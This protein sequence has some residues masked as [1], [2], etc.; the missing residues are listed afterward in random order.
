M[1]GQAW[2]AVALLL[3]GLALAVISRFAAP[4]ILDPLGGL[5]L[6]AAAVAALGLLPIWARLRGPPMPGL[7]RRPGSGQRWC[8][9]CG[10][11][12]PRGPCPNCRTED[13]RSRRRARRNLRSLQ[14][15]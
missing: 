4:D 3:A 15:K 8:A 5:F 1:R 14:K 10:R 11:P 9:V 12:A 2:V 7:F 6:V 13:R